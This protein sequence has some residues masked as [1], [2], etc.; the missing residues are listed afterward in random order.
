MKVR[1]L[2]FAG[3]REAV[4]ADAVEV[5]LDE[6]AT[7]ARLAERLREEHPALVPLARAARFASGT[8]YASPQQPVDPHAEIA[9]IPPVSGG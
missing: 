9:L 4:G 2:M 8:Q 3:A 1:V 5:E 6:G 7:F